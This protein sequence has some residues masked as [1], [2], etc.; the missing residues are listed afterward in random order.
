M[1]AAPFW[2]SPGQKQDYCPPT[3]DI[4]PFRIPLE[5]EFDYSYFDGNGDGCVNGEDLL[6]ILFE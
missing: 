2:E 3:K 4:G 6:N 1:Y 5:Y